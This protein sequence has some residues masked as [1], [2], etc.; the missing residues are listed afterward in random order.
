M[1]Y[2]WDLKKAKANLK[3]HGIGFADSV[4]VFLD[5]HAMTIDDDYFYEK[6]M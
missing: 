6:N 4:S 1:N 2:Q 3:K 5:E